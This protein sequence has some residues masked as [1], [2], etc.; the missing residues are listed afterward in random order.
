[1]GTTQKKHKFNAIDAAIIIVIIAIIGAAA[2]FLSSGSGTE[3]PA[4]QTQ[5]IEYTIELRTI[6]DEF[7]DNF[8]VG[9]KIIDG[10]ELYRIGEIVAVEAVDA[11]YNGNNLVTGELIICDYPDYSN[12]ILTVIAD[13][14]IGEFGRYSIDGGY[15]LSVGTA[16][17]L[18]APNYVGLGYCTQIR[19]SEGGAQ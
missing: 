4:A 6:R 13:A 7:A 2:F 17:Y 1:M 11:T 9:D 10:V 15:D 14:A 12:V 5:K 18:R 19:Q 16:I 3:S 8:T